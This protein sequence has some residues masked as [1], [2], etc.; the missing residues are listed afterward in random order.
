LTAYALAHESTF[1][2]SNENTHLRL[3][4]DMILVKSVNTHYTNEL[5]P[6][7]FGYTFP[8]QTSGIDP[9]VDAFFCCGK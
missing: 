2:G 5:A 7:F 1:R 3:N 9:E 6:V 4:D 8:N